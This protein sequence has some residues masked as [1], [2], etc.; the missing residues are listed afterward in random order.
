MHTKIVSVENV[1]H[2]F[3]AQACEDLSEMLAIVGAIP[4][5]IRLVNFPNHV[6]GSE[7]WCRPRLSFTADM[8][9]VD[10]KD[11]ARGDFDS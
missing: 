7:C 3:T 2:I 1:Q 6:D 5:G 4:D 10:H 9:I 11:L 8:I